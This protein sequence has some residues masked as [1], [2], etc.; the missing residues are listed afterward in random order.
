[1][2]SADLTSPQQMPHFPDTTTLTTEAPPAFP[3]VPQ[4]AMPDAILMMVPKGHLLPGA[5]GKIGQP[6][7]AAAGYASVRPLPIWCVVEEASHPAQK[8]FAVQAI[9][10]ALHL[11]AGRGCESIGLLLA[12]RGEATLIPPRELTSIAHRAF[13]DF[14]GDHLFRSFHLLPTDRALP[15]ENVA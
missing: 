3:S 6:G 13:S 10:R 2:R 14:S 11:A 4:A 15:E 12:D 7:E 8:N 9:D 1:M 5:G